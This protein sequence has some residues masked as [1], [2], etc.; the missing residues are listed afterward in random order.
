MPAFT[1][2]ELLPKLKL[3]VTA[4]HQHGTSSLSVTS[5]TWLLHAGA[6]RSWSAGS[7]TFIQQYVH[8]F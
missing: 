6:Q 1:L 2:H 8:R 3:R 7:T 5:T 4:I